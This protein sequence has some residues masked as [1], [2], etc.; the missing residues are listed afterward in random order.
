[1]WG[2]S[3]NY[4]IRGCMPLLQCSKSTR[5]VTLLNFKIQTETTLVPVWCLHAN[6]FLT[7]KTMAGG[8]V[9]SS[10]KYR[11]CNTAN[12]FVTTIGEDRE[13]ITHQRH[14]YLLHVLAFNFRFKH[15]VPTLHELPMPLWLLK[16][17]SSR[18]QFL[19]GEVAEHFHLIS[20]TE[21]DTQGSKI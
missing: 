14:G 21:S 10:I 15:H 20:E 13:I 16:R 4:W 8:D 17:S 6:F 9:H 3:F 11:I 1:M 5:I 18:L 7:T 2:I 12:E 19:L